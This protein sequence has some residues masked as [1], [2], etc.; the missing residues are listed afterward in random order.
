MKKSIIVGVMVALATTGMTPANAQSINPAQASIPQ[1]YLSRP[2]PGE[3]VVTP[4][5]YKVGENW[6][7]PYQ[8][9]Q[10][11]TGL[12][13]VVRLK[14]AEM[15]NRKTWEI[16]TKATEVD[17]YS[18][19]P[20]MT[21]ELEPLITKQMIANDLLGA[22]ANRDTTYIYP[23]RSPLLGTL[24]HQTVVSA[25]NLANKENTSLENDPNDLSFHYLSNKNELVFGLHYLETTQQIQ[26][27]HAKVKQILAKI[28]QPNM[29]N[30][31]KEFAINNW[32]THHV[33][34]DFNKNGI[35][36][37]DYTA[38]TK[39]IGKC[40]AITSLANL[41]LNDVGVKNEI[42]QGKTAG[43]SHVWNEVELNGK[44]YQ[45]DVTWN[46][47]PI[48]YSYFNLTSAQLAKTHTWKY[49]C[50]PVANTNFMSM[51]EHSKN[52]QD[53]QIL[54]EIEG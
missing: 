42:V 26:T 19:S 45:L 10:P 29:D 22:I 7:V 28:I 15:P 33:R 49:A 16:F 40:I 32:I 20:S 41:M 12:E 36:D 43:G 13:Y 39:G 54:K 1:V 51:L 14:N 35:D 3:I 6:K 46:L 53:K 17:I 2:A 47:N 31:D 11:P 24:P 9:P 8:V 52:P 27:V 23:L 38:I 21:I 5:H 44:W 34:Y 50:L 30:Y 4:V 48:N 37:T 18:N 25:L